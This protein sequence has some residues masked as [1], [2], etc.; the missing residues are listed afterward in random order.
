MWFYNIPERY[1]PV[2]IMI[3][4]MYLLSI[5]LGEIETTSGKS[6]TGCERSSVQPNAPDVELACGKYRVIEILAANYGRT[7]PDSE[8][9]P[10]GRGHK[11]KVDCVDSGTLE[12]VKNLCEGK[13]KC[14]VSPTNSVFGDPCGGTY[15]YLEVNYKCRYGR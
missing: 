11:D 10:Y 9:C 6:V 15:K 2:F 13:Q 14:S 12:K 4:K 5:I 8:V 3:N 7:R 1:T